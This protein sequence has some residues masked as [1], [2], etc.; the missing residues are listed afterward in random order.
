MI[1]MQVQQLTMIRT[2]LYAMVV[3][4]KAILIHSLCTRKVVTT[5]R[6]STSQRNFLLQA[7][8][9][10]AAAIE[11][12]EPYL[13]SRQL[14]V[15][16]AKVFHLGVVEDPLP[17][18][19]PYKGRLAIPYITPSGVVDIRFR[20]LGND[21]P[22]YMGLVG[23]KTTMFNTQAC[24]VAD[25]YICVTEGEFDCIMMSSKTVHPTVGIPGAN[26]WK[27]HYA[28]ILDDFDIVIVLADGDAAGLEFGKKISRELGNVNIV[29]M[30]EGED[31]NSMM[32]RQGSDWVDE[33]IR[34]C[35]AAG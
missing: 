16:E 30:P 23:A 6:L 1:H 31:V 8:Q 32:I 3:V 7:T 29:S 17:G 19:E 18:H 34:E 11:K 35:I 10:Y 25:K 27:P 28:K 9:R 21:D 15:D 2:P 13:L 33:R 14:S 5:V 22:K 12:A 20:A 4:S 24:F 26:N